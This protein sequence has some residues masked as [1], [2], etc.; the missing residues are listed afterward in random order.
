MHPTGPRT[1]SFGLRL[2]A[3]VTSS[4]ALRGKGPLLSLEH[5]SGI[6]IRPFFAVVAN[7]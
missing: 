6:I 7:H 5:V 3:N 4:R 1:F 2:H